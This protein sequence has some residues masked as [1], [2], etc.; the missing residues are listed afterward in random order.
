MKRVSRYDLS[1]LVEEL[2]EML[3]KRVQHACARY[4]EGSRKVYAVAGGFPLTSRAEML[5]EGTQVW[6]D[7][8]SL[9]VPVK[10][11]S[12]VALQNSFYVLGEIIQ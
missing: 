10:W 6:T 9:P 3:S 1:G 5:V 12:G 11:T 2:P 4:N 7:L 8:P